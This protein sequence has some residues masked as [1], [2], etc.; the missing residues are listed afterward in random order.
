M[1]LNEEMCRRIRRS[2]P[3]IRH[4]AASQLLVHLARVHGA[5][6]AN[7]LEDQAGPFSLRP[8]PRCA[9]ADARMHQSVKGAGDEPIVDEEVFLDSEFVVA[10]LEIAGPVIHD[11]MSQGQILCAGGRSDWIGLHEPKPLDRLFERGRAEQAAVQCVPSKGVECHRE[12]FLP[13]GVFVGL[14]VPVLRGLGSEVVVGS[15]DISSSSF[16]VVFAFRAVMFL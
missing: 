11:A 7:E 9:A 15:L 10:A 14:F 5:S 8:G 13:F 1:H 2:A 4:R 3:V 16:L 6:L 12:R